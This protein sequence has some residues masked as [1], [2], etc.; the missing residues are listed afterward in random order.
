[1]KKILSLVLIFILVLSSSFKVY[2]AAPSP[3]EEVVYGLLN[4]DGSVQN[5]YVVNIFD[6]GTITD[7]GNYEKVKNLTG[8]EP[9]SV[10][11]DMI[12]VNTQADKF[13]YQ[14]HLASK[15]LPWDIDI[16]YFIND[17]EISGND[18]AGKSGK[19]KIA[20]SVTQNPN[21]DSMFF[22]NYGLQIALLLD[23]RLCSDIKADKAAI[24]EAG[25]KKQI[26]FTVLPGNS[27]EGSVTADVK[28]FE[29]ESISVNAIRLNFDL[30]INSSEYLNQFSD[31]IKGIEELDDGAGKLLDGIKELSDGIDEYTKGVKT[32]KEEISQIPAGAE[33]ISNGAQS[34]SY[35]LSELTKQNESINN[36][37][38]A[39]QQAAFDAINAQISG[40]GLKLPELTPENYSNVLS[41]I[42]DFQMIKFQLDGVMQFIDG[43]K[44]YTDAVA[45]IAM[46]ADDLSRGTKHFKDASHEI[47]SAAASIYDGAVKINSGISELYDGMNS[48]KK[49]TSEFRS[50]TSGLE[51]K[52]DEEINKL[53][54][55]MFGSD[56]QVKSFVSDKNTGIKSLQFVLRTEPIEIAPVPAAETAEPARLTFWQK[57]LKLFGLYKG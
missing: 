49:G 33:E 36:G 4:Y 53:L 48:Y 7:F 8:N 41:S 56:N 47:A 45:Q 20:I 10:S 30:D 46:G 23:N 18:L 25:G 11:G 19:L 15:D 13:Y 9:I 37:A 38:K 27:F 2:A 16:K 29:M 50:K 34:L 5:L 32:F 39:L 42:P 1:M 52:I 31:L 54:E 44:D 22:E 21:A 24:A 14:G 3:K 55:E 35:A 26:N 51:N 57:L 17:T 28:N 43:L 6:G 12:T 40:M